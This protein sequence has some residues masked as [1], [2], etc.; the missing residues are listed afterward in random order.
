[1][2]NRKKNQKKCLEKKRQFCSNSRQFSQKFFHIKFII[3]LQHFNETFLPVSLICGHVICRKC[4]EK[5]ENQTKP[6]PHDDWKTT[7]SP[8]EYPNNVALLS[9]IFPR[10]QC[11]TLSGA[12]SEAEKRV[13]QLSIQIAKFFREADSERGGTVSSRVSFV[14]KRRGNFEKAKKKNF[15]N[16]FKQKKISS[17]CTSLP[18]WTKNIKNKKNWNLFFFTTKCSKRS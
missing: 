6:C 3:Y 15:L 13:D 18:F 5:P 16:K 1:M 2:K 8:S 7:H 4:A 11:M 14:L 10:K 9:V 12:V 17:K